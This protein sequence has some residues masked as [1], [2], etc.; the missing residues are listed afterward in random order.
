MRA[1]FSAYKY[2]SVDDLYVSNVSDLSERVIV[3]DHQG[4]IF[5]I[6]DGLAAIQFEKRGIAPYFFEN[7][8]IYLKL[9]FYMFKLLL[10]T[11]ME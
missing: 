8:S 11:F 7:S 2:Y 1:L 6:D 4:K 9:R 5:L 3:S 10:R